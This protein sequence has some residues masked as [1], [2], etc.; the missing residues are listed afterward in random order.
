MATSACGSSDEPAGDVAAPGTDLSATEVRG[1]TM[2]PGDNCLRCHSKPGKYGAPE[3]TAGGTIYARRDAPFDSEGVRGVKVTLRDAEGRTATAITNA[4]GNFYVREPLT[5]PFR[6]TI[7]YE[8]RRK[9]MPID[10]P[11]GSCNACH[12]WPDPSGGAPG[13]IFVP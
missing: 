13:R 2:R 10:A 7:E 11:A 8:G 12:S 5:R 6:V 1:A 4:V 3:W 9:E